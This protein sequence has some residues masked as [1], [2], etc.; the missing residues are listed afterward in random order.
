[1]KKALVTGGTGFIGANLVRRLL[2]DGYEVHCLVRS[3]DVSWRLRDMVKDAHVHVADVCDRDAV[4][5]VLQSAKPSH[6]FHLATAGV[7][8]GVSGTDE[9][10]MRTNILG[11]VNLINAANKVGYECFI[12][13]GSS[14]EYGIKQSPMK[15]DDVCE[16]VLAYGVSKLDATQ[17]AAYAARVYHKPITTLRLFSPYGPFDDSHRF[18]SYAI[19]RSL[20]NQELSLGN[21]QSVRDYIYIEDVI[22][23]YLAA[24]QHIS[25]IAG[26]VL[27]VGSGKEII[28]GAVAELIQQKCKS[29]APITWESSDAKRPWESAR[30]QADITKAKRLLEW[31]PKISF[32]S[33]LDRT[34][35]WFRMNISQYE[36]LSHR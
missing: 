34:I 13:T 6:I 36:S 7:Y 15:E 14:S 32:S 19:M 2:R 35:E 17:Y 22:D 10:V 8:G 20:R 12:N 11:L 26:E 25:A 33:G 1:M 3:S 21:P 30:W 9:Q 27:N 4:E 23:A 5:G 31:E 24:A 18:M 29:N 28:I 16:P